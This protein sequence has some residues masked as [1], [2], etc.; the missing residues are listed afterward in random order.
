MQPQEN[1]RPNVRFLSA[2]GETPSLPETD[3]TKQG[4]GF[5]PRTAPANRLRGFIHVYMDR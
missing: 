1:S 2:D 4:D 3:E 5:T